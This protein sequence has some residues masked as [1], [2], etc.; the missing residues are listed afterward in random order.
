MEP[1][2]LSVEL[3]TETGKNANNRL[4]AEKKIP[5]VLYGKKEPAVSLKLSPR[6]LIKTMDAE[7]KRNTFF[8]LD[9]EGKQSVTAFIRDV[10]FDT[11]TGEIKHIDFLRT[12][13]TDRVPAIVKFR[14]SGRAEGVK[15]GGTLRMTMSNLAV[16]CPAS[17]VPAYIEYDVT[18]MGLGSVL[19]VSDLPVPEGLEVRLSP[20]QALVLVSGSKDESSSEET[21]EK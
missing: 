2:K 15:L 21:P 11:L 10:Q 7:K 1:V 5:A 17:E 4:R 14:I 13:A 18:S 20:R 9:I 12:E 19:R 16:T 3:R 8:A 6:D